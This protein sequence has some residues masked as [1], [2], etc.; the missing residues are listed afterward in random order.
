MC[1]LEH[2]QIGIA[3]VVSKVARFSSIPS[4]QHWSAVKRIFRYLK[5][6]TGFCITY[7]RDKVANMFGNSDADWA[8]DDASRKSTSGY[9]FIMNGGLISWRSVKQICIALTTAE[10]E[11]VAHCSASQEAIW[12][13]QLLIDLKCKDTPITINENNQSAICIAKN[14]N[15]HSKTKHISIKYHFL[16]FH[17]E[18]KNIILQ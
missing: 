12:L 13:K 7:S 4:Q 9:L 10:A 1:L 15:Y 14:D 11:Y 3:F 6:T 18:H 8:G 2:D 17:V 5:G 16:R